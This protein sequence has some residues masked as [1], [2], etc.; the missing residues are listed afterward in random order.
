MS[1]PISSWHL[2]TDFTRSLKSLASPEKRFIPLGHAL[3]V[4]SC[5]HGS[6]LAHHLGNI[7]PFYHSVFQSVGT[8]NNRQPVSLSHGSDFASYLSNSLIEYSYCF[9]QVSSAC[10]FFLIFSQ[11]HLEALVLADPFT[12]LDTK[13][14]GKKT[15]LKY[16][17]EWTNNKKQKCQLYKLNRTTC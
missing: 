16:N 10:A 9:I 7:L 14:I 15:V 8:H 1:L 12:H 13:P 2:S 5:G 17:Q 4:D 6:H 11:N 3:G